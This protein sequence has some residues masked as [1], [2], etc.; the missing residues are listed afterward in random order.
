MKG[1]GPKASGIPKPQEGAFPRF[2]KDACGFGTKDAVDLN[3]R[4]GGHFLHFCH[5]KDAALAGK[6]PVL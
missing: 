3:Q 4:A 2:G 5:L 1:Y 6:R